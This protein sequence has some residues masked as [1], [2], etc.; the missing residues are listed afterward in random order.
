MVPFE[1][2]NVFLKN[3][4]LMMLLQAIAYHLGSQVGYSKLA[5]AVGIDGKTVEAPQGMAIRLSIPQISIEFGE[6]NH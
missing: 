3:D 6:S 5:Q 2:F 1:V 4:R